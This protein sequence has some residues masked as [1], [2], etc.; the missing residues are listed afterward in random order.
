AIGNQPFGLSIDVMTL[1]GA[2]LGITFEYINGYRWNELV[3]MFRK[4]Q[5]DLLQS[6]YKSPEREEFG[7]FTSPFYKDK[8]VFVVPSYSPGISDITDLKGKIVAI[9]KGWGQEAYM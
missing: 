8:T 7:R 5:L 1:L 9:S 3:T 6:A 2:R 4:N